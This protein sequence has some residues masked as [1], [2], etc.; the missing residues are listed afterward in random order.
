MDALHAR[1]SGPSLAS[2]WAAHNDGVPSEEPQPTFGATVTILFSDLRGFTNFTD[3]HGDAAAYRMVSDYNRVIGEQV[4]LN[5]GNIVKTQGDSWMVAFDS[6]RSALNCAIAM[7]RANTQ[8]L[9]VGSDSLLQLG[10]GI[11]TGEPV[12]ESSD[13]FGSTVNLA[14]R[15][16]AAAGPGQILTSATVRQLVGRVDGGEFVDRGYHE[17]KGFRDPQHLYELD[18]QGRG[19]VPVRD[20]GAPSASNRPPAS[21]AHRRT[22]FGGL[23]A[24]LLLVV[25]AAGYVGFTQLNKPTVIA[26]DDFADTSKALFLDNQQGTARVAQNQVPW[27]YRYQ[28]G[29]L[30]ADLLGVS[31]P[32]IG[33]V[34]IGPKTQAR[35]EFAQNI[36]VEVSAVATRSPDQAF[37]GV[38]YDVPGGTTYRFGI[39]P[40]ASQYTLNAISTGPPRV[41]ARGRTNAILSPPAANQIR[42]DVRGNSISLLINGNQINVVRDEGVNARPGAVGIHFALTAPPADGQVEVRFTGFKVYALQ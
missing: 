13:F 14:A 7:Q 22:L 34:P 33:E 27:T 35:G 8:A 38:D 37:Y 12:R 42:M 4:T 15:I 11:N 10:I 36:G 2:G 29:A 19:G 9:A 23:A 24:T 21:R 32:N 39:A 20:S 26:S 31:S 6:A 40:G 25:A 30:V 16:C 18:W 17:L 1:E 28:D 5:G 3:A 41:L